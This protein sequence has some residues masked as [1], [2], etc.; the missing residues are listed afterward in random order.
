ML[1][2]HSTGD[3]RRDAVTEITAGSNQDEEAHVCSY[4]QITEQLLPFAMA[5]VNR[6][7]RPLQ[8]KCI[9]KVVAHKV[10]CVLHGCLSNLLNF[11]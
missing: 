7:C 1:E 11:Y 3:V 9:F 5:K 4:C 8:T 10:F 6:S 2:C